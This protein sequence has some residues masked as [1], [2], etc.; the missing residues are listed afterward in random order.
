V[1]VAEFRALVPHIGLYTA[2]IT[3][4]AGRCPA[5]SA[6]QGGI[7]SVMRHT[8]VFCT[9][10]TLRTTSSDTEKNFWRQNSCLCVVYKTMSRPA[11]NASCMSALSSQLTYKVQ[12]G[13]TENGPDKG[14][15][16]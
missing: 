12:V 4:D 16:H 13:H 5:Q 10:W 1:T 3:F 9:G 15:E 7:S 11:S 8:D 2:L 6:M 14:L